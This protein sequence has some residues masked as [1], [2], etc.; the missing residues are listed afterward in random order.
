MKKHLFSVFIS[1]VIFVSCA[2]IKSSAPSVTEEITHPTPAVPSYINIPTEVDLTPYFK[3]AE[4]S[5]PMQYEGND[6]P[7]EGLR[8]YYQFFR[9]PFNISGNKDLIN[10][11]FE[12][13]Y[14]IK[15]SYCAKCF[16]ETC[17][18]PTPTFSCGFDEALRR[19]AIGYSSKIKLLPNYHLSSTTTL[20]NA[21]AID[22][23]QISF[24]NYDITDRLLKEVKSQL[25]VIGKNVD[26]DIADYDLKPYI[27]DIWNQLNEVQ[28]V[29]DYGYFNIHPVG[30]SISNIN[31]IGSTLHLMLGLS[32]KPVFTSQY[33]APTPSELPNL[34]DAVH[35]DGFKVF[36]DLIIQYQDLNTFINKNLAEKTFYV[37]NKKIIINNIQVSGM[38]NGKI[39]MKL[40]FKGSKKGIVYLVG[41][42][43]FDATKN[44]LSM[45][46]LSFDLKSRNVLLKMANWL[47]NDK[48]TDKIKSEAN[49]DVTAVIN[50]SKK[51]I[52]NQL[53]RKLND[54]V[55]MNGTVSDMSVQTIVTSTDALYLRVL[56]SGAISVKVQ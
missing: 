52:T 17:L 47:L 26:K 6:H 28:Q 54:N 5:T 2:T 1:S 12:G 19:I 46:D 44:S 11:S 3:M 33:I 27:N 9:S 14:K 55:Q 42:P 4:A 45:P 8:Y 25:E 51:S 35:Q 22:K 39:M 34:T 23:C 49:F 32:C 53:N 10:L 13:K 56:S 40:D 16:R 36:T 43:V 29:E 24:A 30:V 38:G 31:M 15:G 18:L 7:C 41:T 20:V 37:K 48:I 50:D 21:T